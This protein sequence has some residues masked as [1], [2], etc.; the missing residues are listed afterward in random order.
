[1][2]QLT[3]VASKMMQASGYDP[4]SRTLAVRFGPGKVY[5]Y[6]DV[7]A[8]VADKIAAAESV[9]SVFAQTVRGKFEHTI[10][11]DEQEAK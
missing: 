7:P 3:T 6:A 1:M 5:H 10:I 4:A 9:G 2:V 11:L 8:E